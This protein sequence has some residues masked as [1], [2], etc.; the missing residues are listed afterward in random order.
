MRGDASRIRVLIPHC[1]PPRDASRSA[2]H[3]VP[4]GIPVVDRAA[5][6]ARTLAGRPPLLRLLGA[7]VCRWTGYAVA[8]VAYLVVAYAA[9]GVVG[10]AFL[11]AVRMIPAALAAPLAGPLAGRF[12]LERLLIGAYAARALAL[13][14]ATASVALG[15]PLVVFFAFVGSS[16]AIGALLRPATI[17]LLPA[18][19]QTPQEL[20]AAN[21]AATSGEGASNLVGPIAASLLILAGGPALALSAA[22]L[23]ALTGAFLAASAHATTNERRPGRSHDRPAGSARA[24]LR[25][26]AGR[27]ATVVIV[28]GFTAQT[29]ARG[30]L[31]TL[32]VVSSIELLGLGNEG[33]GGLTAAIGVGGLI[34][35][36]VV[37]GRAASH[38]LPVVF[39]VALAWWSLPI[40]FIGALPTPLVAFGSLGLVGVANAVLDVAGFTLLQRTTPTGMK[41]TVLGLLEG[42]AGLGVAAGSLLSPVLVGSLG[43]RGALAVTG[44]VLP[45]VALVLW[46][47]LSREG[48][49][50]VVPEELL[51]AFRRM[52]LFTPLPLA[53]V[54][55]LARE[56]IPVRF[57]AGDVLMREGDIGDRF[58]VL[59]EGSVEVTRD[60]RPL[61]TLGPG[62]GIGEIALLRRQV[63]T[64]T[65]RA[66]VPTR[67][68]ALG[69]EAFVRAVTG[70]A[71]ALATADELVGQRLD[72]QE[73]IEASSAS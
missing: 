26:L 41:V 56:A 31:T 12:G 33:V 48:N 43:A 72:A 44:A 59:V 10:V 69:P 32:I 23:I 29:V 1:E 67:A 35:S 14:G 40:A 37:I 53:T 66:L 65:V 55:D 42:A 61:A 28:A 45:I 22:T 52:S 25:A 11:G 16:A 49:V 63:R 7:L 21:I 68:Y 17:A 60:G 54:E 38:R 36:A 15:L 8:M 19:A 2:G 71:L 5:E 3:A 39:A 24:A 20:V 9:D 50:A 18:A 73:A 30:L 57:A 58:L 6:F 27:R 70:H 46:P 34:G 47:F 62:D 51:T 4:V 64:A 13:V